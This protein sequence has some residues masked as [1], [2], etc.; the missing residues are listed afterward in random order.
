MSKLWRIQN[1]MKNYS[2]PVT[3]VRHYPEKVLPSKGKSFQLLYEVER[4]WSQQYCRCCG[5]DSRTPLCCGSSSES[6]CCGS[7]SKDG[8]CGSLCKDD[9]C[10]PSSSNCCCA[11]GSVI[12][13]ELEKRKHLHIYSNRIEYTSAVGMSQGKLINVTDFTS[14]YYFDQPYFNYIHV[15]EDESYCC[16]TTNAVYIGRPGCIPCSTSGFLPMMHVKDPERVAEIIARARKQA[17]EGMH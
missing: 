11:P 16:N 5:Y 8:C 4:E 12:D 1:K 13:L 10:E 15:G 6:K 17:L 7:S 2:T 9:C 14:V 3:F